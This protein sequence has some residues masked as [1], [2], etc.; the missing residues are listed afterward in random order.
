MSHS[1]EMNVNDAKNNAKLRLIKFNMKAFLNEK[2]QHK[3]RSISRI[4]EV[5]PCMNPSILTL[6]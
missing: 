3:C 2:P 4:V 6:A 5:N 1:N